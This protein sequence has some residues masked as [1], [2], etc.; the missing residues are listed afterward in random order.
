MT[1]LE[2]FGNTVMSLI[3]IISLLMVACG[4]SSESSNVAEAEEEALEAEP[5]VEEAEPVAEQSE[6]EAEVSEEM[7]EGTSIVIAIPENPS[8]FN[9]NAGGG[10]YQSQNRFNS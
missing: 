4:G 10:D 8:S 6:P 3:V 1:I 7:E 9:P 2:I 5:E